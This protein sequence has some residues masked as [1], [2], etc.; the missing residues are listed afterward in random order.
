[1]LLFGILYYI[2]LSLS[3]YVIFQKT[4]E[5]NWKALI[6]GLN[7]VSWSKII[8]RS[9]HWALLLL[10]PIVNLFIFAGLATNTVRSFGKLGFW[11]SVLAVVVTPLYFFYLGLKREESYQGPTLLLESTYLER[12]DEAKE[13]GKKK[14]AKKL[15]ANNPYRKTAVREWVDALIFAIFAAA[16]IRM[17]IFEPYMIPTSSMEGSLKVGDFLIVSKTSYGLR[18]PQTIAM[19]PLLHNR[20][21]LLDRES[22]LEF[23]KLDYQRLPALRKIDYN[24]PVVFNYPA[25]DS[26]YLFPDRNWSIQDVRYD[27]VPPE[28]EKTINI[29]RKKLVTR[30]VDKR[31]HYIKRCVGLPGDSLRIINRQVYINNLPVDNKKNTQFIYY[32]KAP[33][34]IN[35]NRF[36]HWGIST[37]DQLKRDERTGSMLLIMNEAQADHIRSMDPQNKVAPTS[38]Y[39]ITKPNDYPLQRFVDYEID[40]ANVRY[41]LSNDRLILSL[42]DEQSARL[43]KDSLLSVQQRA[44]NPLQLFPHDPDNYRGWSTDNFGP[45]YIPKAGQ[46]V[47]LNQKSISL[48][49]RIITVYEGHSLSRKN[50]KILIDGKPTDSYTFEMNYYWMMGDNRHNSEDSRTWGFVPEDHIVG[51]PLFIWFALREGAFPSWPDW[52]RIGSV[53]RHL[54]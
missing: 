35:T 24:A 37:E 4:D 33:N 14:L 2:A 22:Y 7:F 11:Q 31:D 9:G 19:L 41:Q 53:S 29:G 3:L 54:Q 30:P 38:E 8:G 46:E 51:K 48:Y 47:A 34:G 40:D 1:M 36:Y 44:F 49:E 23:I 18:M 20:I 10:I 43:R 26:V 15:E 6:P 45:I 16:F 17:F 5:T 21:P 42:T 25:G 28:V 52:K 27:A 13:A 50:G 12:I 39:I 32:V